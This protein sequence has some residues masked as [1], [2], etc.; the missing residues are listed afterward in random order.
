MRRREVLIAGLAGIALATLKR[1]LQARAD[2]Q[3]LEESRQKEREYYETARANFPFEVVETTGERAFD[4]WEQLRTAGRGSPLVLGGDAELDNLMEPFH[5]SNPRRRSVADILAAAAQIKFPE[6]L[7][8]KRAEDDAASREWLK[9]YLRQNPDAPLPKMIVVGPDG[10]PRELSR[11]ETIA[12]MAAEPHSPPVGEWPSETPASPELTLTFDWQS[13][14]LLKKVYIALI[15]D[16]DWT[17]IPA[18]MLWGGWN[19]CPEPEYHVAALRSWRDRFG[20]HLVGLGGDT[21]NLTAARPPQTRA[22]ALDL[23]REQYIYCNDIVDQGTETL[24]VLAASLMGAAWWF[25]W[26]D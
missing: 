20:V 11:E 8:H 12:S 23:A 25:F 19:A 6:D 16:E 18:H 21:M 24:S 22:A 4:T 15:P 17:T 2:D 9:Q 13:R 5:P 14:A 3:N 26:W 1:R 10:T 7:A